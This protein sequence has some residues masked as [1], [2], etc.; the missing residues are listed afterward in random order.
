LTVTL[1]TTEA[2]Q[3]A[4]K[5]ILLVSRRE[6][7]KLNS[8]MQLFRKIEQQRADQGARGSSQPLAVPSQAPSRGSDPG[9]ISP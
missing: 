7:H 3:I 8:M 2:S 5:K 9:L 1:K 4:T 6:T